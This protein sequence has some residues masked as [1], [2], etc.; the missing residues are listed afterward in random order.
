MADEVDLSDFDKD[1][2]PKKMGNRQGAEVV[3]DGDHD[4]TIL[5]AVIRITPKTGDRIL[6]LDMRCDGNGATFEYPMF[7]KSQQNADFVGGEMGTLGFDTKEWSPAKGRPFSKE[8]P[9]IL[10]LLRGRRFRGTKKTTPP[11]TANGKAYP[12]I[13]VNARLDDATPED[14]A[15]A[16]PPVAPTAFS[17]E[18]PF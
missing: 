13:Y 3:P 10:P 14:L 18:I 5:G 12:N 4:F 16:K 17:D 8:L 2:D 15:K 1:F 11:T 6:S 7:L 9:K